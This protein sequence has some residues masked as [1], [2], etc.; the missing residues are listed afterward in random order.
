MSWLFS[1]ALVEEF[2]RA[3]CSAG[4]PCAQLNVMLTAQPFW[5]NDKPIDCSRLSRFGLTCRVLTDDRGAALLTWFLAAFRAKT[6]ASQ[7]QVPASKASAVDCGFKWPR[8]IREVRPGFAY[9]E[10]SPVLT[11]RGLDRVLADLAEVGFDARWGVLGAA[12]V[13]APHLRERIW[14]VANAVHSR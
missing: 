10:N 12:D 13:R 4:E 11:S 8:I 2:S 3:T 7:V 9:V 1:Q 14:I 6:S 5:R